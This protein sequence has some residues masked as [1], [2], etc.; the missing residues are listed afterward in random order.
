[1]NILWIVCFKQYYVNFGY[2]NEWV[3]DKLYLL[4][5][6]GMFKIFKKWD[7]SDSCTWHTIIFFFQSYF[8][9]GHKFTSR[10]V[11]CLIDNTVCTFTE[12]LQLLIFLQ[13]RCGLCQSL[14]CLLWLSSSTWT[15]RL[16]CLHFSWD[17]YIYLLLLFQIWLLYQYLISFFN[18]LI[19]I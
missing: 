1:M 17:I 5:N 3:L 12:F 4:N 16:Y 15:L 13:A 9:N 14:W 2:K 11:L 18:F 8:L 10:Q 19:F 6:V 7:L